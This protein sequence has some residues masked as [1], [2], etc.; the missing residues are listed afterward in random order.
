MEKKIC[1]ECGIPISDWNRHNRGYRTLDSKGNIVYGKR[2]QRQHI[3]HDDPNK[4]KKGLRQNGHS[5]SQA[6]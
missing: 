4:H 6:Y 1:P 5:Y 3:R 2:C